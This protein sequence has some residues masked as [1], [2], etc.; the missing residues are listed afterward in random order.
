VNNKGN[1]R[2][3]K[4]E[5]KKPKRVPLAD[6]VKFLKRKPRLLTEAASYFKV[7]EDRIL[8]LVSQAPAAG[9][10]IEYDQ[11]TNMIKLVRETHFGTT[12]SLATEGLPHTGRKLT[13]M[14]ISDIGL[15]LR[16]QQGT[17]LATCYR[18]AKRRNVAFVIING[19]LVAG[20]PTARTMGDFFLTEA[21]QQADYARRVLP[22]L[23]GVKQYL[24][25][26]W[27]ELSHRAG[28]ALD[29]GS[30]LAE[31]RNDIRYVGDLRET[32]DLRN[33]TIITAITMN[34]DQVTYTL[35]Y[36]LR[37][38]S[39]NMKSAL[40]Y[41]QAQRHEP[42]L[43][44]VGGLLTNIMQPPR[45]PLSFDRRNNFYAL[46]SYALHGM[47]PSQIARKKRGGSPELGCQFVTLIFDAEDHL[48]DIKF[49]NLDLTAWGKFSDYQAPIEPLPHLSRAERKILDLLIEK[50]RTYGE[51]SRIM[52]MP[53][54]R[55]K[56]LVDRLKRR[57]DKPRHHA[58]E[59]Y[60]TIDSKRLT[61]RRQRANHFK[62]LPHGDIFRGKPVT[63]SYVSDAHIGD[64]ESRPELWTESLRRSEARQVAAG[65]VPGDIFTGTDAYPGEI[66]DLTEIGADAQR[67]RG[68]AIT[69]P[70]LR[71]IYYLV[72]GSSHEKKYWTSQGH[73]I[74]STF[75]EI[76]NLRARRQVMRYL[77]GIQAVTPNVK[78]VR[79][80]ML[81]PKGGATIG[82]S[83]RGQ[84]WIENYMETVQAMSANVFAMG[85]LHIPMLFTYKGIPVVMVPS[86]ED[87]TEY[88]KGKTLMPYLGMWFITYRLDRLGNISSIVPEY[89]A[90]E[91]R[92]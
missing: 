71:R 49:E 43:I 88:L 90:Y 40:A 66:F 34:S 56:Q 47:T 16:A 45:F 30:L 50:P 11:I 41:A 17:A 72:R 6:L 13:F 48:V 15:G 36:A 68:L 53:M 10:N 57:Q 74:V 31:S 67:N 24:I 77:G 38:L 4:V 21:V 89:I 33:G 3:E 55:I 73:D 46:S 65:I 20:K 78:G 75:A 64:K 61:L 28:D 23:R 54:A 62:P 5:I 87:Q 8:D 44:L 84:V 58:Y 91:P 26:G 22:R 18:E 85:H 14:V 59:I 9:Y 60:E 32:F 12:T 92:V 19:N 39:E 79:H 37:G 1:N 25:G 69:P 35:S 63:F 7:A 86:L 76:Y 29:V 52:D 2:T 70:N 42:K 82:W 27:R 80:L 51:L 81:H 83:Y